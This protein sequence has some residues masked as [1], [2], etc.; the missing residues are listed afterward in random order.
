MNTLITDDRL[1]AIFR[2]AAIAP[3]GAFA[4]CGVYKGGSLKLLATTFPERLLVGFDTFEGLPAEQWNEAEHHKPGEFNDTD[5][6]AVRNFIDCKN[7]SLV[8]GLFPDSAD[9]Y[10]NA[11]FAFVHVDFDFYEGIKA[12]IDFFWPRLS[13]G[14]I[15]IFDD[16]NW[17]NCPGVKKALDE[18]GLNYTLSANFQAIVRKPKTNGRAVVSVSLDDVDKS[19][20]SRSSNKAKANG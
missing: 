12:A 10:Q 3:A 13:H 7:V 20:K 8:K 9:D 14:G 5:I 6:D 16:F 17:P 4:E 1:Q 19:G 18:S 11:T 2:N 15:M